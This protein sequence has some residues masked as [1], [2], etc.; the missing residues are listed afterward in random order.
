MEITDMIMVDKN[1]FH[2]KAVGKLNGKDVLMDIPRVHIDV[3]NMEY[4]RDFENIEARDANG[5]LIAI[6]GEKLISEE[7][8]LPIKALKNED[9]HL[10]IYEGI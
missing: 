6:W 3:D 10:F 4:N 9:G 5:N 8:K 2:I 7:L 1:T